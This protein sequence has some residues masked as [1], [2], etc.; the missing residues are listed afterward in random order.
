MF[1]VV[2]PHGVHAVEHVQMRLWEPLVGHIDL[3]QRWWGF[4]CA[5]LGIKVHDIPWRQILLN[6]WTLKA[7]NPVTRHSR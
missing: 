7:V 5:T 6:H 4:F 2:G 1:G 3:D